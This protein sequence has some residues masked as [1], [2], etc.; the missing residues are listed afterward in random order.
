MSFVQMLSNLN[1]LAV[2]VAAVATMGIGWLW[3]SPVLFGKVWM[4]E[5]N[6]TEEDMKKANPL[7]AML[8]S[9]LLTLVIGFNLAMFLAGPSDFCWGLIAGALAGI[10]WVATSFG[11]V[12]LFEG[13]S[14]TLFLVNAGYQ[15]VSFIVMGGII[16]V[17][18]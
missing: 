2:I 12:Y 3:Y 9:F 10:G 4:Q 17:W 11:I 1:Y 14:F 13:K 6:M 8:G 5:I 16:G 15:A 18:K 7:K